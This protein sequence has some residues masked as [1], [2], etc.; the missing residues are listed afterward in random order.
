MRFIAQ[1]TIRT[2]ELVPYLLAVQNCVFTYQ[3]YNSLSIKWW[4]ITFPTHP[5]HF[6]NLENLWKNKHESH[7]NCKAGY[8]CRAILCCS[9]KTHSSVLTPGS[10]CKENNY[11]DEV[12]LQIIMLQTIQSVNNTHHKNYLWLVSKIHAIVSLKC[13]SSK[14]HDSHLLITSPHV[15]CFQHFLK[16]A[17]LNFQLYSKKL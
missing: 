1:R 9:L 12:W 6:K 14:H 8:K 4:R 15:I 13:T 2:L 11:L 5:R 10:Q 17:I 16:C 7:Q 3:I